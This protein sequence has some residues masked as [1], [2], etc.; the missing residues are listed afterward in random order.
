MHRRS[1]LHVRGRWRS[2]RSGDVLSSVYYIAEIE[3]GERIIVTDSRTSLRANLRYGMDRA[4][5]VKRPRGLWL[6]V[7][8]PMSVAIDSYQR[9]RTYKVIEYARAYGRQQ[10]NR[11]SAL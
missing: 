10:R 4:I 9:F 6:R 5:R 1:G 2:S 7:R 3:G 11:R 8:E